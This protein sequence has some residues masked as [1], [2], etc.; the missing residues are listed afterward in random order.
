MMIENIPWL[1]LA[2]V[3]GFALAILIF[4]LR[5][6]RTHGVLVKE[7]EEFKEK[8][9]L[10]QAADKD[11]RVQK[12]SLEEEL[13]TARSEIRS[14]LERLAIRETEI[15][16][17]KHQ[18]MEDGEKSL[19][20]EKRKAGEFE[21]LATR[22]LESQGKK[23]QEVQEEKMQQLLQPMGQRLADFYQSVKELR[24]QSI[25]HH[26]DFKAQLDH[27]RKANHEMSEEARNLTRAL[28]G[29]KTQGLWGELVLEKVLESSGLE[30]NREYHLQ[31]NHQ[32]D[33][34]RKQPDA[35]VTLPENKCLIIDAKVS[36]TAY[37]RLMQSES[38]KDR[39]QARKEHL[40]SLRNH[41]DGL[42]KKAYDDIAG[43][44]SP[45]FVLLFIAVEPAFTEAIR[46]DRSLFDYAFSR[47]IILVT[48]TTLLATLK[49]IASVWR[50]EKQTRNAMAI[51]RLGGELYD[52]FV[53]FTEDL[54]QIG[55]RLDQARSA[56][57]AAINKLSSG[58]GNAIRTV[59]R[60]KELGV[61]TRRE[62]DAG[63]K[64]FPETKKPD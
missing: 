38:D 14:Y 39:D 40:R 58:R 45:E 63:L 9:I 59:E 37:L 20:E 23:F 31:V 48:P 5:E 11:L 55:T 34:G 41:V 8:W 43:V 26:T 13:H 17:L 46:H 3:S 52:K 61:K 33:E 35:I 1:I 18:V 27:L 25:E 22:I 64:D 57:E 10:S 50:Q 62:L 29:Q 16:L 36:L 19:L 49:T 44:K 15:R 12:K 2:L 24:T 6:S 60:M 4:S 28:E 7:C 32:T 51:A 42:S 56:Q 30:K 54:Q 53:G 21:A 47:N